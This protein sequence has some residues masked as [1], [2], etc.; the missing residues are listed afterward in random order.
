MIL[1]FHGIGTPPATIGESERGVWVGEE[2]FESALDAATARPAVRI[3]FDD[4]NRSD[5]EIAL[6]ALRRRGLTATFF[7]LA[8]RLGAPGYL[9]EGDV[10]SLVEAGMAIGSHGMH[11]RPWRGLSEAE[12]GAELDDARRLLEQAA[13]TPVT[14]AACPFGA[15]D[16]RVL[17][18]LR[19]RGYERVYTSDGGSSR[20]GAWLQARNT[21]VDDPGALEALLSGDPPA[22]RVVRAAKRLVK[23][24][25]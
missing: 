5:V 17:R 19:G 15:Y 6:P 21:V 11:H 20:P 22:A 14:A 18:L 9:S 2:L 13:G 25:R 4:G 10:G 24:W 12:L 1:N 7:V 3:T 16:R 23:R 8:G